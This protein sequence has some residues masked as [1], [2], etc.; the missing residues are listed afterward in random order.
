MQDALNRNLVS[1]HLTIQT[2]HM[3]ENYNSVP[4]VFA[5]LLTHLADFYTGALSGKPALTTIIGQHYGYD[6]VTDPP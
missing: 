6:T 2:K 1:I 5:K 3:F 4:Y